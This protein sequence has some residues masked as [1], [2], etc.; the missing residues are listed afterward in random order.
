MKTKVICLSLSHISTTLSNK[1]QKNHRIYCADHRYEYSRSDNLFNINFEDKY[2]TYLII[3]DLC[4]FLNTSI[5]IESFLDDNLLY[6]PLYH[7]STKYSIT[8]NYICSDAFIAKNNLWTKNFLSDWM[9]DRCTISEFI[10]K[11]VDISENCDIQNIG[12]LDGNFRIGANFYEKNPT[13]GRQSLILNMS[14]VS[15]E[16]MIKTVDDYNSFI[17]VI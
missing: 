8:E 10:E 1:I 15:L 4:L 12:I 17:G 16:N 3:N 11:N 2:E 7:P 5:K 13:K 9:N 6:L 14:N